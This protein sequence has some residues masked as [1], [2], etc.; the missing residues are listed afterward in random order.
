[1]LFRSYERIWWLAK[2]VYR[3]HHIPRQGY[4]ERSI[5]FMLERVVSIYL[6]HKI[7]VEKMPAVCANLVHVDKN[8]VYQPTP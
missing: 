4:Q 6:M 3:K 2:E 8:L 1:M 7:F 5:N